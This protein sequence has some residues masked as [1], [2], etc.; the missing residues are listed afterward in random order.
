M[1]ANATITTLKDPLTGAVCAYDTEARN[2]LATANTKALVEGNLVYDKDTVG[3][4]EI[5]IEDSKE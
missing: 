2:P 4:T 3:P 1:A 5:I